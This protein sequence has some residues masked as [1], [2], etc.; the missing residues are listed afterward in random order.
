MSAS[1]TQ[2]VPLQ[3]RTA[4]L[5]AQIAYST[6]NLGLSV[7]DVNT[8]VAIGTRNFQTGKSAAACYG[9]AMRVAFGMAELNFAIRCYLGGEHVTTSRLN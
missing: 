2:P 4:Y 8:C 3:E 7:Y 1:I 5:A 9:L 6:K